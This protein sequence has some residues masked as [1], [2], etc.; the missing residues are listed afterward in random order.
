M[1]FPNSDYLEHFVTSPQKALFDIFVFF[2]YFRTSQV[3]ARGFRHCGRS[4]NCLPPYI[5]P[6]FL[7]GTEK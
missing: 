4:L 6:N 5:K 1:R 3:P 2:P 7:Q